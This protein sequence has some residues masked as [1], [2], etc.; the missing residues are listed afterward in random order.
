MPVGW[1]VNAR[2]KPSGLKR[3]DA[4]LAE[5][6]EKKKGLFTKAGERALGVSIGSLDA[7]K[8]EYNLVKEKIALLEDVRRAI[9][10]DEDYS[11]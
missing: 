7:I 1:N 3:V 2:E 11:W 5:L 6:R 8:A 9:L 10:K 4:L